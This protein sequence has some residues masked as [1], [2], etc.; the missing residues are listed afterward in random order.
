[1]SSPSQDPP[2]GVLP[3][4]DPSVTAELVAALSPRLRKRLDAGVAKLAD[5]PAVRDGDTVRIAVDDT[6]DVELHAPG[7]R[8]SSADAVRCG[9]LLA[10][11]CLHRAAA[12]SAAPIADLDRETDPAPG[13][14]RHSDADTAPGADRDC[15]TH[16][17]PGAGSATGAESAPNPNPNPDSATE[18]KAASN[19]PAVTVAAAGTA[20]PERATDER[21]TAEQCAAARA[22]H[23]AAAAVLEA[24]TD[25]SGAVLQAELLRAAHTARLAGLPRSAA[26]AVSVVTA[27]RAARSADPAYRLA[28]LVAA[29]C[30]VLSA[31]H[32]VPHAVGAELAE[33]RG[34]VRQSYR[35]DGSLRLYGLF[36]EPVLTASGYAGAVTWTADAKG[37]LFQVPD[38]APGGAGRAVGAAD[39][40]VRVGDTS[41]THRELS[42]AGLAVSGATVSPTGRLGAGA[43]VR[44]VRASGADWRADPL[45]QLWAAPPAGQV[46][47][48]LSG[49][50]DLLFLEVTLGGTVREAAGD[51]LLAD[52]EGVPLRLV[53]AHD[54]PALPHRDNLRLLAAAGGS[55]LRIVARLVPAPYPRALLLAA[56][57]PSVPGTRVDLGLDRLQHAD[58]PAAPVT[59]AAPVTV[60]TAG[61]APVHL[62][63]RRVH[64]AVSGGRLV[65]SFP[66]NAGADARRL[67]RHGLATAGDLLGELHAAAAER[68]RDVF[69]RLLPA[70]P[71]RFA[72]A[73]L[74]AA[75]YTGELDRALCAA[76]WGSGTASG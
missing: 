13:T 46:A 70:D 74:A 67:G 76:A 55:R 39:R 2:S 42:R 60:P 31:A 16:A 24:G 51:C 15:E 5:R 28:D 44:A 4:V 8:V 3:P 38:V 57:H 10:P 37:R 6:I 20:E 34:S 1:M 68:D 71:G 64:Q 36:S 32:R 61:E 52:C 30:E 18:A 27:L 54:H 40:A 50:H 12:A 45:D 65:L 17:A 53:A 29:L 59:S 14:D 9:C 66:G 56:E 73:W 63:R 33:L 47:R 62:L 22:V 43:G 7:G 72:R 11:D 25:G 58:L 23:D 26:T 19:G 21:A 41:L 48:A 35:P 49:G 69:G 75:R